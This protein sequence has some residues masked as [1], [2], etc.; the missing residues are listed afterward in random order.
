[1]PTCVEGHTSVAEDYCDVCGA[2]IGTPAAQPTPAPAREVKLAQTGPGTYEAT[3]DTAE[4]GAYFIALQAS[5]PGGERGSLWA[6]TIVAAARE[7][8]DLR[9]N[10]TLLKQIASDTGGRVLPTFDPAA[11]IFSREGLRPSSSS[12]PLRDLLTCTLMGIVLV[13]VGVRRVA[14]DWKGMKR[15][16]ITTG[17]RVQAF[18]GTRTVESAELSQT[19]AG[20]GTR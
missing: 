5:G 4:P 20:D 13:D 10:D 17:G 1:M 9:S 11:G 7:L 16:L 3:L 8:R 2:P 19:V 15:V 12:Q 6:G 18:C 14:W